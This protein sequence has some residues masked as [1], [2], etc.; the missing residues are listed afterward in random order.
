MRECADCIYRLQLKSTRVRSAPYSIIGTIMDSALGFN[1]LNCPWSR[2]Q[3]NLPSF[4]TNWQFA[5]IQNIRSYIYLHFAP[6]GTSLPVGTAFICL[7]Y[8]LSQ[9][10]HVWFSCTTL[11]DLMQ[12]LKI[13]SLT[14]EYF[15]KGVMIT[16]NDIKLF[17]KFIHSCSLIHV[18]TPREKQNR[19]HHYFFVYLKYEHLNSGSTPWQ[20]LFLWSVS[21]R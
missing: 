18:P 13:N 11:P 1:H 4:I 19:K 17:H 5:Q 16:Q 3:Q 6:V 15:H 10:Q 20:A 2:C 21:L 14:R 7:F 9:V 8:V 12:D